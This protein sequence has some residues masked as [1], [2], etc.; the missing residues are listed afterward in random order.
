MNDDTNRLAYA[1]RTLKYVMA[2]ELAEEFGGP[3]DPTEPLNAKEREHFFN[4]QNY[5][6]LRVF[7]DAI[8]HRRKE[9]YPPDWWDL[10]VTLHYER[11]TAN[12]SNKRFADSVDVMMLERLG[13]ISSK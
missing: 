5:A 8:K 6:Q 1:Y 3:C 7:C 9:S 2:P 4:I 12:R 11:L 10:R 13:V